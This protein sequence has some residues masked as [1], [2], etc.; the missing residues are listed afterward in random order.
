M[1]QQAIADLLDI[2]KL[3]LESS[4]KFQLA[5]LGCATG[6]NTFFAVQNI[7]EAVDAK[8]KLYSSKHWNNSQSLGLEYQIFFNDHV[9]NDF[10]TLF[11]SFPVLWQYF[12][13]AVPGS[14]YGRLFPK[15]SIHFMHSSNALNWISRVPKEVV[16]INSPAWNEGSIY[17][18]GTANKVLDAYSTQFKN[19]IETFLDARAQE[20]VGGGLMMLILAGLPDDVLL[21][22]T[23]IGKSYD[24]LGSC[25]VDM[26]NKG[27]FS[28]ERLDSFN[29][30]Q[31]YPHLDEM[32]EVI[33]NN[34][35]FSLERIETTFGPSP[36]D[37][38]S[39]I[40]M[41]ASLLRSGLEGIIGDQFGNEIPGKLFECYSKKHAENRFSFDEVK[42]LIAFNIVL[43]RKYS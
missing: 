37:I 36:R 42:D 22:Q 38:T 3:K 11:R 35:Y 10:N 33:P 40:E 12:A 14:F 15:R 28:K 29:L 39:N 27:M 1:I 13:A 20:L 9:G 17:C 23:L 43:K 8:C 2:E 18:S 25:L 31:Y 4:H 19:D 5:D 6:T 34:K 7:I 32:K 21:C 26:A 24:I 30:P 16:D 41:W